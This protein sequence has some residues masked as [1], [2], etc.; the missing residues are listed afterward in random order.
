MISWVF[1]LNCVKLAFIFRL[2]E[3]IIVVFSSRKSQFFEDSSLWSQ[4]T[5][6]ENSFKYDRKEVNTDFTADR[7][8]HDKTSHFDISAKLSMDFMGKLIIL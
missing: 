2:N 7:T 5:V 4:N 1:K 3:N 6:R 8:V